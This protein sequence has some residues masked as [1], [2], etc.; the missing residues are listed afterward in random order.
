MNSAAD[1]DQE[2]QQA[3][4]DRDWWRRIGAMFRSRLIGFTYRISASFTPPLGECS[5]LVAR[6][7]VELDDCA[8][9]LQAALADLLAWNRNQECSE[10]VTRKTIDEAADA[11]LEKV[12]LA[13]GKNEDD[14]A[15]RKAMKP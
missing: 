2:Y 12:A 11:A 6:R 15:D 1:E 13:L 3:I 9:Q 5:G 7:L 14:H 10:Y 4:A 8:R